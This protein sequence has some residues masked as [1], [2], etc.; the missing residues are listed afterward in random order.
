MFKN[1]IEAGEKLARI[2]FDKIKKPAIV[3]ALPRGGVTVAAVIAKKL[4]IPLEL[5]L[6]RKIGHPYNPEFAICALTEGGVIVC[7]DEAKKVDKSWLEKRVSSETKEIQRRQRLYLGQRK[8]VPL[9]GKTAVIVDDGVATGL[10]MLAAIRGAKLAGAKE[11][12]A[13][14]PVLPA[15]TK[16]LL[17]KEAVK[18]VSV[19]APVL[20]LGSVGAYYQEFPQVSDQEVIKTLE[21]V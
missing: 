20:F 6:V 2:L 19:L 14:I 1:R 13:A 18:V 17:E 4:K 12:I 7:S 9:A 5:I 10:T 11:I 3:L 15:E 8:R 16:K 21:S